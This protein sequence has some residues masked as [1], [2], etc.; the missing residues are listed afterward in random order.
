[1]WEYIETHMDAP[2]LLFLLF[3]GKIDPTDP[4]HVRGAFDALSRVEV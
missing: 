4:D 1:M 3:A 2:E